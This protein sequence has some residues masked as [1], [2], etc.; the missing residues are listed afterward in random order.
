[1]PDNPSDSRNSDGR[2]AKGNGGGPGR[3]RNATRMC[4][5]DQR[6]AGVGDELIDAALGQA[7]NGNLRAIELLLDRIWPVR[8]GRPVQI[9]TSAIRT[10]ADLLPVGADVTNAMLDGEITAEEGS[11]AG[12]VLV[13]HARMIE[14][15]D[16]DRRITALEEKRARTEPGK[17]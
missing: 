3:P 11:A 1:M 14:E 17:K 15:V 16:L 10:T 2:F 6:V 5:F 12:R 9:D 13:A 8:R 7:R 4:E